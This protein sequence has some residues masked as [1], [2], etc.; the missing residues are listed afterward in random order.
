MR[1][2]S[3]GAALLLLAIAAAP[4]AA[5][6]G[7]RIAPKRTAPPPVVELMPPS[8]DAPAPEPVPDDQKIPVSTAKY[9]S[10]FGMRA[11]VCEAVVVACARELGE[12]SIAR[13]SPGGDLNRKEAID[14]AKRGTQSFVLWFQF[15]FDLLDDDPA[16]VSRRDDVLLV[17]NYVLFEPGTAKIRTQGKIYF[18]SYDTVSR[19]GPLGGASRG[20][21]ALTPTETGLKVAS[22]V[23]EA[24][25]TDLLP[26]P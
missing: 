19:G 20:G 25:Q 3:F 9:R 21:Q 22:A 2:S 4:C 23:L 1:S 18:R 13:P 15:S 16:A 26:R 11:D 8:P 6:S 5:Q 17:A 7:R 12:S 24:L 14:L 10:S